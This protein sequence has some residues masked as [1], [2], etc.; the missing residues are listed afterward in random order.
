MA[1]A[2]ALDYLCFR[3]PGIAWQETFP[4]TAGWFAEALKREDM[5]ATD[6]RD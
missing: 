5:A 1:T 3:L 4:Q 6:P 2:C